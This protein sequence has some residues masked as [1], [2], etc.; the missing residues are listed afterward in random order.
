MQ[1]IIENRLTIFLEAVKKEAEKQ[2]ILE[3]PKRT[4]T[5]RKNI[6]SKIIGDKIEIGVADE[7][8]LVDWRGKKVNYALFQINGTERHFIAPKNKKAL[9]WKD[10]GQIFFSKGHFVDGIKPNN[11]LRRGVEKV[12]Y[13]NIWR[14]L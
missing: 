12:N 7:G 9:K 3:A 8:M 4:G 2:V 13:S 5:L 1:N 14:S 11:F 6:Y 10:G